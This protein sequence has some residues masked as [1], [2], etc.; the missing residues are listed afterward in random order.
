MRTRLVPTLLTAVAIA[1]VVGWQALDLR[2]RRARCRADHRTFAEAIW[3]AVDG[4]AVRE[5][6][7]GRYEP[8]ALAELLEES[9]RRFGLE[10]VGIAAGDE[11][12][13]S[14]GAVAAT[15][16]AELVVERAFSPLQPLGRGPRWGAGRDSR[17]VPDAPLRLRI[18]LDGAVLQA[19]LADESLR[20]ILTGASLAAVCAILALAVAAR[21]RRAEL[22]A[23]LAAGRERLAGL[24]T[25]SRIGAGLV[26]ETKNPLGVVRGIAE[27]IAGGKLAGDDV[28]TAAT[29]I[30]DEADR[31]VA[32]LDEFLLLSR[33]ARLRREPVELAPLCERLLALLHFDLEAARARL[34]LR[35]DPLTIDADRDQLRR[36][37]LNLLLN[38][39]QAVSGAGGILELS[40]RRVGGTVQ[41]VVADDGPGVPEAL[42]E[43][44]FEPYVSG[45]AGGT[46]LGLAIARRIA[47]DHGFVLRH[48]AVVPHG[49]RLVLEVPA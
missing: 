31:T 38:A 48:E 12:L 28:R 13:G 15:A 8:T 18:V 46:G 11:L 32:R 16:A 45:R 7:G 34:V 26:H 43:T 4:M 17:A 35:I 41:I 9:R 37:L 2:H 3:S 22:R 29:S 20:A 10:Y 25:L 30:V 39:V 49:A 40:C 42:R 1:A 47:A 23:E 21:A 5:F 6:R 44:M 33:P 27:R 19:R 36:L 24:E 14:V